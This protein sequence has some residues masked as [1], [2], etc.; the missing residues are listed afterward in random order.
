[1][2]RPIDR[3]PNSLGPV[4]QVTKLRL[5]DGLAAGTIQAD[6]KAVRRATYEVQWFGL[7]A[8][9]QL[10]GAAASTRSELLIVGLQPG[11][12]IWVR[13]RALRAGKYGDWSEQATRIANV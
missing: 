13:V 3:N 10:L 4:V 2:L 6:W 8:M 11:T 12:Q 5:V 1:M 7:E 9:Q